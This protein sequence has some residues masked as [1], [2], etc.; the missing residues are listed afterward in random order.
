MG[1]CFLTSGIRYKES[2]FNATTTTTIASL[3]FMSL[4]FLA[5]PTAL[6]VMEVPYDMT[7]DPDAVNMSRGIALMLFFLYTM[8]LVFML[9]THSAL[10]ED[11]DEGEAEEGYYDVTPDNAVN[12]SLGLFAAVLWL[13]ISLA[14]VALC[15]LALV[16]SIEGSIWETK[17]AFLGFI[18]F[19]FLGNVTDYMSACVVSWENKMD[20]TILVTLGSSMQMLLFTLPFLVILG[21]CINEPMTLQFHT[22]ENVAVFLAVYVVNLIVAD[23]KSNYLEGAMCIAL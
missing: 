11:E 21:W 2:V 17:T 15:T 3:N 13:T 10:F 20:I 14:C 12:I 4:C 6:S 7:R 1:S 8:Y 9:K 18:L 22:F 16:S 19:P 23:G 5:I